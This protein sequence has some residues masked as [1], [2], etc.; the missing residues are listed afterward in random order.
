VILLLDNYDSFVHNLARYFRRLG[1]ATHVVRSDAIDAAS[2]I[3]LAPDAVVISPGPKGPRET[4]CSIELLH[5][6]P[7]RTPVLGV[8]LGHQAIAVAFGGEVVRCGPRHGMSSRVTHDGSDLFAGLASPMRVGR[9]HSLAV[10]A[11]RLPE[12]LRVTARTDDGIVM[13]IRHRTRP[14][15][16]VQFHPESVLT[17]DGLE[18][19]RNFVA[20][21]R[22]TALRTV[23]EGIGHGSRSNSR[24]APPIAV[25]PCGASVHDRRPS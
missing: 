11:E 25:I 17:D 23:A 14:V 4:G 7:V 10:D 1:C 18:L 9:Y 19:L 6:L 3:G 21:T 12:K 8:C 2:C 13:G 15:F 16:G 20:L 24:A 5:R 22:P